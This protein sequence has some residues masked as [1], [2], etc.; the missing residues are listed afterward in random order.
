MGGGWSLDIWA[1]CLMP[2]HTGPV[3][4]LVKQILGEKKRREVRPS[5]SLSLPL[6]AGRQTYYFLP[7]LIYNFLLD[8]QILGAA[9]PS[10]VPYGQLN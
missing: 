4:V 5:P 2:K 3:S 1:E 6:K 9:W 8:S 10:I 7:S